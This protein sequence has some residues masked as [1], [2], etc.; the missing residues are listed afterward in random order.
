MSSST[1]SR[2]IFGG[3]ISLNQHKKTMEDNSFHKAKAILDKKIEELGLRKTLERYRILEEIYNRNDHF[4]A[5]ELYFS[6]AERKFSVS[7][8]TVYNTLDLFAELGLVIKRQFNNSQAFRYEKAFGRRQH[9]HLICID[10]NKVF[11]FCD[12]RLQA[13]QN[14]ISEFYQIPV[15]DHSLI[16]Y[17]QCQRDNCK[18]ELEE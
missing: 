6:F 12:P 11:E 14:S 9:S 18:K 1:I 16:L 8:S 10:C 7:K 17:G 13:I 15:I 2:Q 4:E 5:E 3:C